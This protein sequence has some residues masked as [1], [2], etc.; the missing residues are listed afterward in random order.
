MRRLLD[1][2]PWTGISTWHEHDHVTHI[3]TL[4]TTY[5]HAPVDAVLDY[6]SRM[7]NHNSGWDKA[8]EFR[9]VGTIPVAVMHEWLV[10]YGIDVLNPA[11]WP[12]V[13]KRLNSS[14]FRKLRSA[15]WQI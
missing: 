5:D 10:K 11:H 8:H 14:D 9:R 1:H 2:D 13:K 7:A 4:H 6:N 3:T 15:I 12:A